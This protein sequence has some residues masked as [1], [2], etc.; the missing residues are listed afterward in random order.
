MQV[1]RTN[2]FQPTAFKS[3]NSVR[4]KREHSP[5]RDASQT[6]RDEINAFIS[7]RNILLAEAEKSPTIK[8]IESAEMANDLVVDCLQNSRSPYEAQ[9]LQQA[10]AMR[11][12]K[13]CCE[14]KQRIA[15]LRSAVPG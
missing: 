2:L 12:R 9:C 6:A 8:A 14:A 3:P 15:Q 11:E 10:D 5:A 13:V 4:P 7:I 1:N